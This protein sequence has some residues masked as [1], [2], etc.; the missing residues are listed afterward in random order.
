MTSVDSVLTYKKN[1]NKCIERLKYIYSD[2]K[3]DVLFNIINLN[4]NLSDSWSLSSDYLTK[5]ELNYINNLLT[6]TILTFTPTSVSKKTHYNASFTNDKIILNFRYMLSKTN[7]H[8]LTP[9]I[10]SIADKNNIIKELALLSTSALTPN[11]HMIG[12]AGRADIND[13]IILRT[14]TDIDITVDKTKLSKSDV[15]HS[16]TINYDLN[17]DE[18]YKLF[19]E[20]LKTKSSIVKLPTP[21]VKTPTVKTPTDKPPTDKSLVDQ[22]DDFQMGVIFDTKG[23]DLDLWFSV[24]ENINISDDPNTKKLFSNIKLRIPELNILYQQFN[25]LNTLFEE[26]NNNLLNIENQLNKSKKQLNKLNTLVSQLPEIDRDTPKQIKKRSQIIELEKNASVIK[27]KISETTTQLKNV[28]SSIIE[29]IRSSPD[30]NN[31]E[32]AIKQIKQSEI[33]LNER[34]KTIEDYKYSDYYVLDIDLIDKTTNQLIQT[35]SYEFDNDALCQDYSK[36]I[37]CLFMNL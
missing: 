14:P 26:L 23:Y 7:S 31:L 25:G 29:Q 33:Y 24:L 8:I 12:G 28:F 9:T 3:Y 32:M 30:Y 37:I 6:K 2:N 20:A 1:I 17:I 27:T 4:Y 22:T 10:G 18:I 13:K 35:Y 5:N 36:L 11:K 21:T 34:R 15:S 19:D 16:K